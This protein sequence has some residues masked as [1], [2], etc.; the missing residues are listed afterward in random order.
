MRISVS[1]NVFTISSIE[2]LTAGVDI[3]DDLAVHVRAGTGTW[4]R[5]IVS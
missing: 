5:V 1:T 2:A 3:V 4:P